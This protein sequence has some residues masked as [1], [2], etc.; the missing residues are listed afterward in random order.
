MP[1]IS[2]ADA[3]VI[4]EYTGEGC[5]VPKD[6]TIV[7]FHPS[8]IEVENE[9]FQRCYNLKEVILHEGLQKIG[10]RAFQFCSSLSSITL[11]STITDIGNY[12]FSFCRN[13]RDV[14]L[15]EGLQKIGWLA[16][17]NCTPLE[18]ITFPSTVIEVDC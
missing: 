18:S 16:F 7:R 10:W 17:G 9:A 1:H 11:P 2:D 3:E 15:N 14:I 4:F 13:L 12:A 8:V 5:A 6:V